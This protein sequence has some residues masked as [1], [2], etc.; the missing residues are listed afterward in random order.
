MLAPDSTVVTRTTL[1]GVL[2]LCVPAAG[3]SLAVGTQPAAAATTGDQIVAF[4]ASQ[5]GVPYCDNGGGINGP[6]NGGVNEAGCGPGVKG[7]DCV[8]LVQYAVYQATG[9]ALPAW[10]QLSGVGTVIAPAGTIVE[11]TAALLPGD[12]VYWGGSGIDGYVHS[13][14]Y[15]GNGNVWDAIGINQPV[16]THTMAY[17]S[18]IYTYDGAIRYWTPSTTTS[19]GT[20]APYK[21]TALIGNYPEKVSGTGWAVNGDTT[22]TLNQ[23]ASTAY[24]SATCDAANQVTATLGTGTLAGTFKN[25]VIHLAVGAID[26]SGDTCGVT[27][28]PTCFI[29]AVGNTG[30]STTSVALGFTVPNITLTKTTAVLGNYIEKVTAKGFPIGDTVVAQ[31]CDASVSVPSTISTHCDAATQISGTVGTGGGAVFSPTGVTL[32]VDNAYSDTSGGT[33]VTGGTCEVVVTDSNNAA[34]GFEVPVAFATPTVTVHKTTAV[35]GNYLDA[36]KTAGFPIGDTVVAREC[37]ASVSVPS[38][39]STHCD[40]ATQISGTVAATGVVAFSPTGVTLRVGNAYADTSGGTCVTAGTCDIVVTD[41]NNAAIGFEVAVT[42]ATP[43][44]TVAKASN[45]AANYVDTVTAKSFP[46]GDTVTA[47][48]CDS[49]VTAANLATNCDGTTQ[50]VGT[51]G[52]TGVVTFTATGV[53]IHVGSAFSDTAS[54]SCPAGG[55]CEVVVNDSTHSGFY[56]AVPIGLA[57]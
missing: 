32:R 16:Q 54:G 46:I 8:S 30:D 12:A 50:I 19:G 37:D 9:I 10:G 53:T 24:S 5:V 26:G 49:N 38:T 42:F 25:A 14:I 34:I 22:V 7:F 20:V 52:S 11:D 17:L 41:S 2:L 6:T 15:A 45:V 56:I 48:E 47:Q 36:V 23:C 1:I 40:A 44:A 4:A 39:I 43:T 3:A 18:T 28:S 21:T 35:L 51:V 29:V 27:G 33:C 55:A 31:E 57:A 13:G